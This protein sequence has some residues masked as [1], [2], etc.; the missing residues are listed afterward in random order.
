MTPSGVEH[1]DPVVNPAAVAIV[2]ISVTPS[3][4]EHTSAATS[5][6]IVSRVTIS[7]TPSGVEHLFADWSDPLESPGDDFSD[8]FGR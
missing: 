8:A 5:R 3:G 1:S 4:V 2:T 6:Q 7:V